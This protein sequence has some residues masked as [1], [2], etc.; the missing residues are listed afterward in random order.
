LIAFSYS[1][2]RE[3]SKTLQSKFFSLSTFRIM[4]LESHSMCRH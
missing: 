1:L 3:L 4:R 2:P